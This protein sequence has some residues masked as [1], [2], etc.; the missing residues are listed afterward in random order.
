MK[1]SCHGKQRVQLHN[2]FIMQDSP[3]PTGTELKWVTKQ[4]TRNLVPKNTPNLPQIQDSR[5]THPFE[6]PG[7]FEQLLFLRQRIKGH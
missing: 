7:I 6:K 1:L 4:R 5:V 3:H 2:S